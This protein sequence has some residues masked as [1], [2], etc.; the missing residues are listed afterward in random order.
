M[1]TYP[2]RKIRSIG[3]FS[4]PIIMANC[5]THPSN[6]NADPGMVDQNTQRCIKGEVQAE[7]HAKA[8]EKARSTSKRTT[9]ISKVTTIKWAERKKAVEGY[10]LNAELLGR[11]AAGG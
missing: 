3:L 8:A 11:S 10:G 4:F 1:V 9:N 5:V 7:W 6:A 2:N